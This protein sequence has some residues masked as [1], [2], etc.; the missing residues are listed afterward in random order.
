MW[1]KSDQEAALLSNIS[2]IAKVKPNI[3]GAMRLF[4]QYVYKDSK[5]LS[6]LMIQFELVNWPF[7]QTNKHNTFDFCPRPD[8][9]E[10]NVPT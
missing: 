3:L 7:G 9:K 10:T 8:R 1:I 2:S 6:I 4:P 5:L